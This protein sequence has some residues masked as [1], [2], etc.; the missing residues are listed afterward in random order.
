MSVY[1]WGAVGDKSSEFKS[2]A[3]HHTTISTLESFYTGKV[4]PKLKAAMKS[5]K[6]NYEALGKTGF[7]FL[8]GGRDLWIDCLCMFI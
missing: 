7:F 3:K 5:S 2:K 8:G 1:P 4:R 6:K